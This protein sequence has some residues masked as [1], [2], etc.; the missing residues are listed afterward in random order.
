M[1]NILEVNNLSID[2]ATREGKFRAV[3]DISF[4]I[5]NNKLNCLLY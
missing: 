2:F 3:D 1:N 4:N 5:E